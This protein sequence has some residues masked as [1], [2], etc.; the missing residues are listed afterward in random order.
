MEDEKIIL[1]GLWI[2][3]M[4]TYLLGDVIR[5]FAGD[6]KEGEM[7]GEKMKPSI[8]L[9][10]F[11]WIGMTIIIG[12]TSVRPRL[13]KELES[14]FQKTIS[15]EDLNES[16]R[17]RPASQERAKYGSN[18]KIRI[19]NVSDQ[20]I[21]FPLD[22][23]MRLFIIRDNEWVEIQDNN[24]YYGEGTLLHPKGQEE[25]SGTITTW[26]RPVL[27]LNFT[28]GNDKDIL[29]IVIIGEKQNDNMEF[30]TPVGAYTD[31]VV[32]P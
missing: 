25:S 1:A 16:I 27:P 32:Y 8:I 5:V 21:Y 18:I 31:I 14:S 23:E 24:Q 9:W 12:C 15:V 6:F 20:P 26:V 30:G 17:V 3:T 4:L 28:S 10:I 22:F 13:S 19:Q 11:C 29:R 7:S 2:A